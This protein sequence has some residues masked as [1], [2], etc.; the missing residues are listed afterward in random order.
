MR[1]KI[2][3]IRMKSWEEI[4]QQIEEILFRLKL[5]KE[6]LNTFR[7]NIEQGIEACRRVSLSTEPIDALAHN[8]KDNLMRTYHQ[9]EN[10]AYSL[11]Q[12]IILREWDE[13]FPIKQYLEEFCEMNK[14]IDQFN[15]SLQTE[16][17]A[18]HS[19]KIFDMVLPLLEKFMIKET[20]NK[21]RSQSA[22]NNK[23]QS[24]RLRIA[25]KSQ[26][27]VQRTLCDEQ[28]QS[29][30]GN[31]KSVCFSEYKYKRL[32]LKYILKRVGQMI[33][34]LRVQLSGSADREEDYQTYLTWKKELMQLLQRYSQLSVDKQQALEQLFCEAHDLESELLRK[35]IRMDLDNI[36]VIIN[37]EQS[38][39]KIAKQ[40]PAMQGHLLKKSNCLFRL[41]SK[42][43]KQLDSEYKSKEDGCLVIPVA[44]LCNFQK[45][46]IQLRKEVR[47]QSESVNSVLQFFQ[48]Q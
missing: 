44:D 47:V 12:R 7:N 5:I 46:A 45:R 16:I 1:Q 9:V 36:A 10:Q 33:A 32:Q 28:S 15:Q 38:Q 17:D 25:S 6:K 29:I 31:E 3:Q 26:V 20:A 43:L 39:L 14:I 42:D 11:H 4:R 37:D 21:R 19:L 13:N 41:I 18:F 40:I 48:Y 30:S 24:A 2:S 22:S 34:Q 27:L 35:Q 8:F 23:R